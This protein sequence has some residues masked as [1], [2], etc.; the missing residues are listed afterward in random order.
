MPVLKRRAKPGTIRTRDA[1][2]N[3]AE[4]LERNRQDHRLETQKQT[5]IYAEKWTVG[6]EDNW[7]NCSIYQEDIMGII[8]FKL[9]LK[10]T[11]LA[12]R[13]REIFLHK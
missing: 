13:Q 12:S 3:A 2:Q 9:N 10:Q 5:C 7:G 6:R 11:Q 8:K 4:Y 1:I